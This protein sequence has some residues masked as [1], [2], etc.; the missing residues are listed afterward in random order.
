MLGRYLIFLI[1]VG[2][3]YLKI[4]NQR[5]FGFNYSNNLKKLL[6]FMKELAKKKHKVIWVGYLTFLKKLENYGYI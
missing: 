4:Q 3:D 5:T 2:F 1:I 6:G